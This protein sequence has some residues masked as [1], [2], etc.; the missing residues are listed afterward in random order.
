MIDIKIN[1]LLILVLTATLD[2]CGMKIAVTKTP[3]VYRN[4]DFN[5]QLKQTTKM[6]LARCIA[7]CYYP[8]RHISI[9]QRRSSNRN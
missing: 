6:R 4:N 5:H 7:S 8:T 2:S 9:R 3:D 1:I